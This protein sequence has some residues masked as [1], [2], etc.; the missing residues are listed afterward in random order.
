MHSLLKIKIN[1]VHVYDGELIGLKL[2][3]FKFGHAVQDGATQSR[4]LLIHLFLTMA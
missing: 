2:G 3:I 4:E 1:L